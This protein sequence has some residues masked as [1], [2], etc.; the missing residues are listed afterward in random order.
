MSKLMYV[1]GALAI[2]GFAVLG[3]MEMQNAHIPELTT[4]AAVK[5]VTDRPVRFTGAIV[6]EER[7]YDE[8]TGELVFEMRDDRGQTLEVRYDG[9][10]PAGFDAAGRA[11]VQGRYIG[12]RLFTDQVLVKRS[13]R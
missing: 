1:L 8:K 11:V 4:V 10:K 5:A 2:A 9:V 3:V 6:S 7:G 12:G 13:S